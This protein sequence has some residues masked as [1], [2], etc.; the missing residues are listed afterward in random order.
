[1]ISENCFL[2]FGGKDVDNEYPGD[3]W[4]LDVT[5][6]NKQFKVDWNKIKTNTGS[7][8]Q[9]PELAGHSASLVVDQCKYLAVYGGDTLSGKNSNKLYLLNLGKIKKWCEFPNL[10]RDVMVVPWDLCK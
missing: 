1:M 7:I 10:E 8:I 9:V 2:L 4:R 5:V 6:E 3:L